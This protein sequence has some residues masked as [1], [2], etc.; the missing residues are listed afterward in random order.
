MISFLEG[1]IIFKGEKFVI[2][3]VGGIGYKIFCG[4]ETLQKIPEKGGFVKLWIH[5]HVREDMDDLYGFLQYAE[6]ELFELLLGVS[7]VGPKG[8]CLLYTSP[9]PRD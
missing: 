1:T 8:G 3:Q 4:Q 6:L 2:V 5:H 9:S 7:G